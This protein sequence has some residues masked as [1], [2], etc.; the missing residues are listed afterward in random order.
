M[1]RFVDPISMKSGSTDIPIA[2]TAGLLFGV[3]TAPSTAAFTF[4]DTT[5][6]QTLSNKT[7]GAGTVNYTETATSDSALVNYG[8][9]FLPYST[10]G[11]TV[12]LAAPSSGV[13]KTL[14]LY[15]TAVVPE[16]TEVYTYV[17]ASSDVQVLYGSTALV[18]QSKIKFSPPYTA[19]ELIGISTNKWAVVGYVGA[20]GSTV[21][22]S[23]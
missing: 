16:T 14:I 23:S 3:G 7:L 5:T 20:T 4:V 1:P 13:R 22:F 18:T 17:D 11:A 19:V 10:N 15:S 6:A 2:S 8:I 21:A 9:S 12:T